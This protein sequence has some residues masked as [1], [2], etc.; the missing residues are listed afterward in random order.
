MVRYKG[1]GRNLY[2]RMILKNDS[3]LHRK[4]TRNTEYVDPMPVT[5]A[6]EIYFSCIIDIF[7]F[8]AIFWAITRRY[9]LNTN[10]SLLVS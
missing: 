9:Q 3:L 5:S 8:R 7:L 2:R 1:V 6:K 10:I 4:T